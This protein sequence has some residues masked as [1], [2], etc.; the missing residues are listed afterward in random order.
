MVRIL[1]GLTALLAAAGYAQ[2]GCSN[3]IDGSLEALPPRVEFCFDEECGQ[4]VLLYHCANV[5]G[6]Q[7]GFSNGWRIEAMAGP[8]V[9][10]RYTEGS[11][12]A[13]LFDGPK[14]PTK[15]TCREI[16]ENYGDSCGF[17]PAN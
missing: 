11:T 9:D 16:D 13:F 2:A 6:A 10:G 15:I 14:D 3:Y 1:S 4:A 17:G 8:I 5:H 12:S 7:W